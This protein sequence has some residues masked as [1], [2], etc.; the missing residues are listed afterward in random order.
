M[1]VSAEELQKI[2]KL[3]LELNE[4]TEIAVKELVDKKIA[5]ALDQHLSDYVHKEREITADEIM[6]EKEA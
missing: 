3:L 5:E 4:A 6:A 2:V 1:I